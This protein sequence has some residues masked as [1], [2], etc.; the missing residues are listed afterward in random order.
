MNKKRMLALIMTCLMLLSSFCISSFAAEVTRVLA[1]SDFQH[2]DGN[3]A[4]QKTVDA[5]VAAIK[6]DGIESADGFLFCGDYDHDLTMLPGPTSKGLN[7]VTESVNRL[8]KADASRVYV[9]G[10]HD[11]AIGTAGLSQSG[12]NDPENGKYGVFVINEDDY[13]WTNLSGLVIKNTADDL[14]LYLNEKIVE[15]YKAPV[16]VISHLP[17]HYSCRTK[18]AGDAKYAKYI[19]DVLNEAGEKGLNI[20]FLFGHDHSNG[21]DDYLGA[22]C[23]C[24]EKGDSINNAKKGNQFKW[25]TETLNFTYMNA[26]YTGYYNNENGADDTLTMSLFTI[27]EDSV[28]IDRYCTDGKHDVKSAGVTNAKKHEKGYAPNTEVKASGLTIT[29]TD[30]TDTTPMVGTEKDIFTKLMSL[31]FDMFESFMN[32]IC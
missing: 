5:I 26:G 30:V 28:T 23:V 7:A 11:S 17:L 14:R 32:V 16:F 24:L 22:S 3:D 1:G 9:A 21:W 18:Q 29:L 2:P 10:N 25:E 27:T 19:F 31:F 15:G 13:M 6:A 8:V 12:N 4:G 20:F